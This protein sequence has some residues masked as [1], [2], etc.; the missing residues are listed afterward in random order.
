M[1]R[2]FK[3][4]LVLL[5]VLQT[6][7]G[8]GNGDRVLVLKAMYE[9][10]LGKPNRHDV[11]V[12]RYPEEP[13]KNGVP[14]NYIKRLLGLA[15]ET[16]AIFFGQLFYTTALEYPGDREKVNPL[17]LW[18]KDY[19]H[20]D[21]QMAEKL[22]KEGKFEIIRKP[23]SVMLSLRRIV[24]DN[25]FQAADLKGVL[26]P[27]WNPIKDSGWTTSDSKIFAFSRNGKEP[28]WLHYQHYLRPQDWPNAENDNPQKR[29]EDFKQRDH[30]PELITDFLAYN[31]RIPS[32]VD[33][34]PHWVGDLMLEME[35]RVE[36]GEGELW[37]ELARGV[38][39][40]Q[41]RWDL[42]SGNCSLVRL[43]DDKKGKE[44]IL[45]TE[46]TALKGPGTYQVRF[47]N[48]D[49]RLTVWVNQ[50][51]PFGDGVT[52]PRSW[53]WDKSQWLNTGPTIHDLKP[54]SIA[55]KG[56]TLQV[57]HLK[58]WRDTYYTTTKYQHSRADYDTVLPPDV[59]NNSEQFGPLHQLG[60]RTMFVQP[61]HYLCL[62]DNSPESADSRS[63]GVV[64][65]RL[66]LGRAL[67]VYYPFGRVGIIH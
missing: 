54:A 40:F 62:G 23:P 20:T 32:M 47:A 12:F 48:F 18:K 49:E 2:W 65:E 35:V 26:P 63:W 56:A 13:L 53:K 52:Y 6:G 61:G 5:L 25:D 3:V 34:V 58:L 42:A 16:I 33:P 30:K 9:D 8:G 22:F 11:V 31:S 59:W 24:Y 67:V 51:L 38:D 36:K 46:L 41:A 14:T 7:C 66:M 28:F 45:R 10:N 17:N 57:S 60:L 44:E 21:D 43:N 1:K 64:P 27:R 19:M 4:L 37:L 29:I 39:R 15:G 50:S 55:G